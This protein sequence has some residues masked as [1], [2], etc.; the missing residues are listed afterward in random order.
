MPR[1]PSPCHPDLPVSHEHVAEGNQGPI[2]P[3]LTLAAA[4]RRV[5]F[6]S[7][8]GVETRHISFKT[9]YLCQAQCS[10]THDPLC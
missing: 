1:M 9:S 3:R 2:P 10:T 8:D 6:W 4:R 7:F 5:R